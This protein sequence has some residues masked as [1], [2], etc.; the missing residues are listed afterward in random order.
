MVWPCGL[1]YMHKQ[2]VLHR[3]IKPDNIL[4]AG[5]LHLHCSLSPP[6]H[7]RRCLC[8]DFN[9]RNDGLRPC[10]L[11]TNT[12]T[13]KLADFGTSIIMEEG[14]DDRVEDMAGRC[15]LPQVDPRLIPL[16]FNT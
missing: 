9:S 11:D 4:L 10:P 6:A 2:G 5:G 12:N 14:G 3:D 8:C 7:P 16:A 15:R 13:A 1:A